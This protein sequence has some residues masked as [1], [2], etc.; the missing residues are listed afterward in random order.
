MAQSAPASQHLLRA[1]HAPMSSLL[2]SHALVQCAQ[3][4]IPASHLLKFQCRF[5][6]N[7]KATSSPSLPAKTVLVSTTPVQH[8]SRADYSSECALRK[9][10]KRATNYAETTQKTKAD[11]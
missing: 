3:K 5:E 10:I 1:S 11:E 8:Q 9:I 7:S 2:R 4:A 6:S